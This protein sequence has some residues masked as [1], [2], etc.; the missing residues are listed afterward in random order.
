MRVLYLLKEV[1][2]FLIKMYNK[3]LFKKWY[4]YNLKY[5]YFYLLKEVEYF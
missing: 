3:Q 4:N 5:A 1:Y 2:N